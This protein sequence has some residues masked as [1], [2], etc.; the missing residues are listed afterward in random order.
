M[1]FLLDQSVDARLVAW[2]TADTILSASAVII[3]TDYQIEK[4][5]PSHRGRAGSLSPMIEILG[6]LFFVTASPTPA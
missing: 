2:L 5:L 3:P 6:S 1:N 4:F